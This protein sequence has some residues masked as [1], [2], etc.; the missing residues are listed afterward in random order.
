MSKT[1]LTMLDILNENV[2]NCSR[3]HSKY[4]NTQESI[5]KYFGYKRLGDRYKL[6]MKC[7]SNTDTKE[8][9]ICLKRLN[10][11]NIVSI[12]CNHKI[13]KSCIVNIEDDLKCTLKCPICRREYHH[14]VDEY[15]PVILKV[16]FNYNKEY[17]IF[18][19]IQLFFY[20]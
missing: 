6:C 5:S 4:K 19:P 17:T 2:I 16:M 9:C 13:C 20:K 15:Y 1:D 7:R 14:V 18:H 8:C 11:N 10:K 12:K 3:C